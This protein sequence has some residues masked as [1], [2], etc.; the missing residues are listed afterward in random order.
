MMGKITI[1]VGSWK[2]GSLK[3]NYV[4]PS[5]KRQETEIELLRNKKSRKSKKYTKLTKHH[6]TIKMEQ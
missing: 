2:K 1:L 3:E 6:E 5:E 4:F